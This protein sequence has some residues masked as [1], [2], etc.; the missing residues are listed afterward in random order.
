MDIKLKDQ[1]AK[2]RKVLRELRSK[3]RVP[4]A[5]RNAQYDIEDAIVEAG[6][7]RGKLRQSG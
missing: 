6:G 2:F 7:S 5:I 4:R 3:P 1:K